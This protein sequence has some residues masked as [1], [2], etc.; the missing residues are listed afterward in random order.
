[1]KTILLHLGIMVAIALN[2]FCAAGCDAK[3]VAST[4]ATAGDIDPLSLKPAPN[5]P[6]LPAET[7]ADISTNAVVDTA[8]VLEGESKLPTKVVVS[9]ALADVVKL[10]QAD[11]SQS[12][13]LTFISNTTSPFNIGPTQ[14]DYLNDL[15]VPGEISLAMIQRDYA[16]A[17]QPMPSAVIPAVVSQPVETV[18]IPVEFPAPSVEQEVVTVA[19]PAPVTVN[20]FYNSL[21]PYGT[22]V[23]VDGYGRCWRP[24]VVLY[25]SDWRP[26]CDNGYWVYSNCGWYWVSDYSWGVTFHYG[27]WFNHAR[28][29]WCWMP[30]TVWGP[31]WVTWRS[32]ASYCGWAPLPPRTAYVSG[33]GLTYYGSSISVGFGFGLGADCYTFVPRTHFCDRRPNHYALSHHQAS[34]VINQTTVINNY[35]RGDNHRIIN[36]GIARDTIPGHFRG[37]PGGESHL[38]DDNRN[39]NVNAS[40]DRNQRNWPRRDP[41]DRSG[42]QQGTINE[43][44]AVAISPAT[45]TVSVPRPGRL[46]ETP[47]YFPQVVP[48]TRN[49]ENRPGRPSTRPDSTVNNPVV[50][51]APVA[52]PT[53]ANQPNHS[54]REDNR[55]GNERDG[56]PPSY[57]V[58]QPINTTPANRTFP[59]G[60]ESNS[61]FGNDRSGQRVSGAPSTIPS[62]NTVYSPARP[63]W[64]NQPA[65]TPSARVE[66]QRPQVSPRPGQPANVAPP[67]VLPR[68][69]VSHSAVSP[70]LVNR[71]SAP[72]VSVSRPSPPPAAQNFNTPGN[73]SRSQ[74]NRSSWSDNRGNADR[75]GFGNRSR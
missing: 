46:P 26:Y 44:P 56:T 23:D 66:V 12:V 59:S 18:S 40:R 67:T 65:S 43:T 57:Q 27:R 29:G 1:M 50:T 39:E 38:A 53:E 3:S 35:G 48:P 10:I 32:S 73:N 55:R 47:R 17:P 7:T 41:G 45:P 36:R 30:D 62:P 2:L 4:N 71:P 14:M 25:Q 28:F 49:D 31:A 74:G 58:S 6:Q 68:A 15:G 60:R 24:T 11:V 63:V 16:I 51:T 54:P 61:R 64:H 70:P 33:V 19:E 8:G 37:R 52:T 5:V 75:G 9:P 69:G 34:Q 42:G 22:W 13:I 21:S 20:Y 72:S